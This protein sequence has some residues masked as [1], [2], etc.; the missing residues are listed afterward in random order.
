MTSALGRRSNQPT[1][2]NLEQ[3]CLRTHTVRALED[4]ERGENASRSHCE[5][6][7]ATRTGTV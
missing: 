7:A 1:I 2:R 4:M 5:D 6:G 3:T